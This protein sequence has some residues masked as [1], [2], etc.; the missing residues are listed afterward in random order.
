MRGDWEPVESFGTTDRGDGP[1]DRVDAALV[2]ASV[3]CRRFRSAEGGRAIVVSARELTDQGLA[4][5]DPSGGIGDV[6][7][8]DPSS[9]GVVNSFLLSWAQPAASLVVA[10]PD[11]AATLG[12]IPSGG[13][14]V[15][16][17]AP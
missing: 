7:F 1:L 6:L 15:V 17:T 4:T 2:D 8:V 14:V 3:G 13:S 9:S 10:L 12:L 5:L 16:R 11:G